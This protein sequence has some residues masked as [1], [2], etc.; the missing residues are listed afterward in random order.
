MEGYYRRNSDNEDCMDSEAAKGTLYIDMDNIP[1]FHALLTQAR[2]E[3]DQLNETI[4]K[5]ERFDL[6]IS[7]SRRGGGE[8]R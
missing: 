8:D 2:Q 3:A 7:F 5:L 6:E 4:R 1:E